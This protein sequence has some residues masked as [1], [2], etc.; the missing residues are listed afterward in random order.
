MTEV[1]CLPV[2]ILMHIIRDISGSLREVR[3]TTKG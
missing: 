1:E 2:D 3:G